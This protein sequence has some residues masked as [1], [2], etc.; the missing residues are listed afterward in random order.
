VYDQAIKN[1]LEREIIVIDGDVVRIADK[2]IQI[3]AVPALLNGWKFRG[4]EQLFM[5]RLSLIVQT[6]SH[7]HQNS[8]IFDPV[9]IA[10]DTQSWVK[11]YLQKMDYRNPAACRTFKEQLAE[12]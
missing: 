3:K 5:A 7:I 2:S 9:V 12:S 6:L 8:R 4:N 1:L 11:A 10:E